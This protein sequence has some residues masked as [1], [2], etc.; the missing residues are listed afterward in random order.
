MHKNVMVILCD[1][2][3]M[4]TSCWIPTA[5]GLWIAGVNS[6]SFWSSDRI[7][8]PND[9][10]GANRL[11]LI[12]AKYNP[13]KHPDLCCVMRKSSET[14]HGYKYALTDRKPRGWDMITVFHH[15]NTAA[16]Y[17]KIIMM[18]K[19]MSGGGLRR[20]SPTTR[21]HTSTHTTLL[22]ILPC[23]DC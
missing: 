16:N 23:S 13:E 11:T 4:H 5:S 21:S 22:L 18:S 6:P 2:N 10:R 9:S 7:N 14:V 12:L 1:S 3:T 17:V 19:S 8:Y 15:Q 20:G